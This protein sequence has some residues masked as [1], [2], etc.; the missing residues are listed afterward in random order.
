MCELGA[1]LEDGESAADPVVPQVEPLERRQLGKALQ[2]GQPHVDEA[3]RLEAGV[4][5]V[6]ALDLRG[7]GVVQNQLLD[8]QKV[9]W[10][11]I[12]SGQSFC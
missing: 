11:T 10:L 12:R 2:R 5:L 4:L 9:T 3:E 7:A 1:A 8:L 6:E